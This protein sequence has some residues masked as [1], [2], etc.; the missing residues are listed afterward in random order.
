ME[1]GMS[2]TPDCSLL[3]ELIGFDADAD[4]WLEM[5]AFIVPNKVYC[6]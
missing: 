5:Q 2:H 1:C 4:D 3:S 6:S